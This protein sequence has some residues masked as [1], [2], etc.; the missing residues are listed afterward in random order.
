MIA[1]HIQRHQ[2][3]HLKSL[4]AKLYGMYFFTTT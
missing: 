1:Q 3:V 2:T 4:N